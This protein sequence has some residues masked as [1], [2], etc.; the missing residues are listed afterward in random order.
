MTLLD[1]RQ[2]MMNKCAKEANGFRHVRFSFD[3]TQYQVKVPA[4]IGDDILLVMRGVCSIPADCDAAK[5]AEKDPHGLTKF[6]GTEE[7]ICG[8]QYKA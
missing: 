7:D 5:N 3:S 8:S 6:E 1:Y 4:D 2:A